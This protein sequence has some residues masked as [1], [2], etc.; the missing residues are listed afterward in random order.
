MPNQTHTRPCLQKLRPLKRVYEI[1][2]I[3]Q[4]RVF[5]A[6]I[7]CCN[8]L[9]THL[10]VCMQHAVPDLFLSDIRSQLRSRSRSAHN[11]V[12]MTCDVTIA[13]AGRAVPRSMA[14]SAGYQSA[15]SSVMSAATSD[16]S[17]ATAA[18][19]RTAK[20]NARPQKL[21]RDNEQLRHVTPPPPMEDRALTPGAL[22]QPV[23]T[24]AAS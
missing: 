3:S 10:E 8:L 9:I 16:L 11:L 21:Q 6:A 14:D 22:K 1:A 24:P 20:L 23:H 18:S 19:R 13:S 7:F 15:S 17:A 5:D 4:L 2:G 12:P